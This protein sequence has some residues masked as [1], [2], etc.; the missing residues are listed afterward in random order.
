VLFEGCRQGYSPYET[1]VDGLP[2][3]GMSVKS[4]YS[5]ASPQRCSG[6]LA[7]LSPRRSAGAAQPWP[8]RASL[9]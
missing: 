1:Q 9:S 3:W 8:T 7:M 4:R 2:I 6:Q 5:A